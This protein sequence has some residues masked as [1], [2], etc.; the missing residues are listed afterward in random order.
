MFLLLETIRI[1]DGNPKYLNFHQER[2]DRTWIEAGIAGKPFL[3]EMSMDIPGEY[4]KG[5]VQ[6]TIE[7]GETI[8][9]IRFRLYERKQI[10]TLKLVEDNTI[11]YHFKFLDRSRID[12]LIAASRTDSDIII[13]R[14][15]IVTDSST[16][17][18]IFFTGSEWHT[19]DAP[20]LRGTTRE[21][22]LKEGLVKEIKIR[23]GDVVNYEGC[24]LINAMR[25]P[26]EQELIP[27]RNISF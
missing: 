20:L 6:C 11:D 17:N 5:T 8:R 21:R 27:A 7:Y 12:R 19:P 1:E 16:A 9:E 18:L 23:S 10:R 24:K 14:N 15:G 13:I 22:L 3:L 2:V 26:E 4:R 25:Y